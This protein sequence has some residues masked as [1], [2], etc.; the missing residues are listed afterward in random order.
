MGVDETMEYNRR[1]LATATAAV[2]FTYGTLKKGFSN[3]KLLQDLMQTGDAFFLR[4]DCRTV[5]AYPL[6]CG[7]YRVPFLL[8][9]P[10]AAGS[11]RV[12]GELYAVSA[13][14]LERLDELEGTVTGHYERLPI[15]VEPPADG[16]VEEETID[17]GGG[18]EAYFAGRSYA[19]EMWKRC[20]KIGYSVY[21]EEESKGYVRRKDRAANLSFLEQIGVFISSDD[22]ES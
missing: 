15:E 10:G 20:G 21:G 6:V 8:N 12:S 11:N 19:A 9:L 14:G 16:G 22:G 17:S 5:D 13:R 18:V 7:P 1:Q 2:I 3:H 4:R